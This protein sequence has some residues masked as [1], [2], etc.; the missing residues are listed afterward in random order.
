MQDEKR[1]QAEQFDLARFVSNAL[2]F[3]R[4]TFWLVLIAGILG[5]LVMAFYTQRNYVEKYEAR[6]VLSVRADNN[7]VTDVIGSG[8]TTNARYTKQIVNTFA[9]IIQSDAM[10]DRLLRELGTKRINGTITPKVI[11]DSNL[12]TLSVRSTNPEDA[13]NILSAVIKCYPDMAFTFIGAASIEIIEAPVMPTAP[14][15]PRNIVRPAAIGGLIAAL[16]V[17]AIL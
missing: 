1:T 14:V 5:A 16:I 3:L 6:A 17:L 8:D 15:N 10:H 9:T 4:R 13:Y 7:T 12:F 11:A 2:R